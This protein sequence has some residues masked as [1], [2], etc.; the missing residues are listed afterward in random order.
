MAAL[1]GLTLAH[2]GAAGLVVE[3]AAGIA[4][5]ALLVWSFWKARKAHENGD[6]DP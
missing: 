2:G 4:I 6:G 1:Q 5:T 3:S